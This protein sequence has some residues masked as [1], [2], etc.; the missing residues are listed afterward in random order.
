MADDS[1]KREEERIN[2][3]L[4]N[5]GRRGS[6][7]TSRPGSWTNGAPQSPSLSSSP[8][9]H[10][11]DALRALQEQIKEEDRKNQQAA[12]AA[13]QQQAETHHPAA[14]QGNGHTNNV[15]TSGELRLQSVSAAKE[16]YDEKDKKSREEE[17]IERIMRRGPTIDDR[18]RRRSFDGAI[19][20]G[21]E[22]RPYR[23]QQPL[24]PRSVE[25]SMA[26]FARRGTPSP[27][28]SAL[29]PKFQEQILNAAKALRQKRSEELV[30]WSFAV[31]ATARSIAE[32]LMDG[33]DILGY[34]RALEAGAN[35]LRSN[36]DSGG[37]GSQ[38]FYEISGYLGQIYI[39]TIAVV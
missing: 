30:K 31:A 12:Q 18:D 11:R 1:L 7:T 22:S 37:D 4:N 10:N 14:Q 21:P 28:P 15:T 38:Y 24:S 2:R 33:T 3:A 16:M 13:H 8:S 19:S 27:N 9:S 35:S 36:L 26:A 34:S 32:G 25:N 23:S 6:L 39:A 5:I 29:G 20:P 17:R